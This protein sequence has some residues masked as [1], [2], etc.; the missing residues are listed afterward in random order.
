MLPGCWSSCTDGLLDQSAAFD[1]LD[2]KRL[3]DRLREQVGL[4][5]TALDWVRSY[6]SGR[7]QSVCVNDTI[8]SPSELTIG[9]PQGSVL[10]PL[11]F[12]CYMLPLCKIIEKHGVFRHSYADD[13]QLF[14]P[15]TL[16]STH[17]LQNQL[18]WME[19]CLEEVRIWMRVNKLKLN[20][21][22]TE[23]LIVA[24][25]AELKI[26]KN[27]RLHIGEATVIPMKSARNLG[28]LMKLFQC[29]LK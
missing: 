9:V 29:N 6:L 5:G 15:L 7:N 19:E 17:H 8:S 18:T 10:G 26:A 20:D 27:I 2:H 25:K 28:Y 24:K 1:T 11:L 3:L 14:C 12:L 16:K 23:V 22:K 21:A 13:L 4:S